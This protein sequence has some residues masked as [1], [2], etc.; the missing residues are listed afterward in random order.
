MCLFRWPGVGETVMLP[1][2][3]VPL[4][5]ERCESTTSLSQKRLVR[6]LLASMSNSRLHEERVVV[7]SWPAD[8]AMGNL[9]LP[10]E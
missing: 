4:G 7:G 10:V 3:T 1:A 6:Y 9:E 2:V 5:E 8:V